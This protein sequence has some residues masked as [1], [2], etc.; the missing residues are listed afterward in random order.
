[1]V[2]GQQVLR[3]GMSRMKKTENFSL[4]VNHVFHLICIGMGL[5]QIE[6]TPTMRNPIPVCLPKPE[7]RLII[8]CDN[9]HEGLKIVSH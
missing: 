2:A 7:F 9:S 6:K 8:R 1:M 4:G 5:S 3:G